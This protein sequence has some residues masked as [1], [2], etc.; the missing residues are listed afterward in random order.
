MR[1]IIP[2]CAV[3]L[4]VS[5]NREKVS[6]T[7]SKVESTVV[8][9]V[10]TVKS[11]IAAEYDTLS[12]KKGD[13]SPTT[14]NG[15]SKTS[16]YDVTLTEFKIDMDQNVHAGHITLKVSNHGTMDHNFVIRGNG[17][18]QTFTPNLKPDETRVMQLD[19]KPGTYDVYC[20]MA[21]HEAKGMK[22]QVEV[23]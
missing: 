18:K 19:L 23:R 16:S 1:S 3:L 20:P 2:I 11:R 17:V 14:K 10:D 15:N 7:A 8:R 21:Q 5:C 9:A 12:K 13:T 4:L 6:D 22:M